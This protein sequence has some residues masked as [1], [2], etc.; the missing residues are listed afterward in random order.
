VGISLLDKLRLPCC[1]AFSSVALPND[2]NVSFQLD[3]LLIRLLDGLLSLTILSGLCGHDA[4][5]NDQV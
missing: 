3:L 4:S 2:F 1:F 5:I